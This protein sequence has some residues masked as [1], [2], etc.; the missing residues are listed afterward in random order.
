MHVGKGRE[1]ERWGN[2]VNRRGNT[3][4]IEKERESE[5]YTEDDR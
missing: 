1:N 2:S 3:G 5:A 4:I